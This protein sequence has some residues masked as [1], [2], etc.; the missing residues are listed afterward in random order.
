M[1]EWSLA[2]AIV[3]YSTNLMKERRISRASEIVIKVGEIQN[4]DMEILNSALKG[5]L[6]GTPFE[7]V[8]FV[9]KVDEAILKCNKCG[10]EFS[11]RET[12]DALDEEEREAIHFIP[13]IIHIFVSCPR[14]G[15]KDFSIKKGRGIFVE[16]IR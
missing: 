9:Y 8:N 12:L 15:S 3:E 4:I 16:E 10:K 1:H 11:Y 5:M 6:K 13:E 14:C 2:Q 7:G